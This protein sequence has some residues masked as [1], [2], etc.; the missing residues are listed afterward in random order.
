MGILPISQL[1]GPS[2][3]KIVEVKVA[4]KSHNTTGNLA[5]KGFFF[6]PTVEQRRKV[7]DVWRPAAPFG[8]KPVQF[9][10]SATCP[11]SD[12]AALDQGRSKRDLGP[13]TRRET[14]V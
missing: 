3:L 9:S 10:E 11:D 1:C 12:V 2:G 13:S 7:C 4:A 5:R 6:G 14:L 8:T